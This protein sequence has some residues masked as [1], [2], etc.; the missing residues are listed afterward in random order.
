MREVW[1][2]KMNPN[3][4]DEER[5]ILRVVSDEYIDGCWITTYAYLKPERNPDLHKIQCGADQIFNPSCDC[6]N[7]G[8]D[9]HKS[10]DVAK[11]PNVPNQRARA[12]DSHDTT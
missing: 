4:P 1:L 6:N 10:K 9:A 2:P 11:H 3:L 12:T 8:G 7:N 5:P